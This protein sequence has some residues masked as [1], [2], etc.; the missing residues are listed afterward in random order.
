MVTEVVPVGTL[1]G[2]SQF[3]VGLEREVPYS[4]QVIDEPTRLVIDLVRS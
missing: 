3:V 2:R 4:V 1:E